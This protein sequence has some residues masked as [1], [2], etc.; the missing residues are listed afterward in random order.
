[1]KASYVFFIKAVLI[2]FHCLSLSMTTVRYFVEV[3]E[4]VSI[5]LYPNMA[6][7]VYLSTNF[8]QTYD[9]WGGESIFPPNNRCEEEKS[10]F[11]LHLRFR[12]RVFDCICQSLC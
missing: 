5:G 11:L 9:L 8:P 2:L 10:A 4:N 12:P 1:M 7:Y 6:R 3:C